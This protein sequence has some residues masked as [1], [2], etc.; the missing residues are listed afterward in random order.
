MINELTS[1]S[2]FDYFIQQIKPFFILD[3]SIHYLD[4]STPGCGPVFKCL[5]EKHQELESISITVDMMDVLSGLNVYI[6]TVDL[7]E[8][9][10]AVFSNP[11]LRSIYLSHME[12]AGDILDLTSTLPNLEKLELRQWYKL[13]DKG[14][15]KILSK[16]KRSLRELV[17]F[18][19]N[20]KGI[21]LATGVKSLPNLETLNLAECYKLKD[22]G[23]VK[24]L[25]ISGGK[26]KV[27]NIS[28]TNTTGIGLE[29]GVKSLPNLDI[30]D[31]NRSEELRDGGLIEILRISKSKLRCLDLSWTMITGIG[32]EEGV[33]YL[34]MLED[35]NLSGCMY[36]KN[37]GLNQ[38]LRISGSKL[39][40]LDL[41]YTHVTGIG[42]KEGVKSLPMLEY[43]HLECEPLT[44][45]GF[46]EIMSVTGDRLKSVRVSQTRIS[47]DVKQTLCI[48]HPSVQFEYF[49]Y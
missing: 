37:E 48:Q 9:V 38:I 47:A 31:L 21:G 10:L 15:T 17:L 16:S 27:L 28:N 29:D 40:H 18:D 44:E 1:M 46:L 42:F 7:D 36:L 4:L 34:P 41:S 49:S 3:L 22:K 35:L 24:V 25:K 19:S 2:N 12:K 43:L 33:E 14:L 6:S 26:L 30:L 23:L 39:I 20:T 8:I 32:L 5:M 13:S 45:Q 11:N